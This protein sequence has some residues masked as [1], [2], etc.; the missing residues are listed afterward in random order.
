MRGEAAGTVTCI[1]DHRGAIDRASEFPGSAV[2][3][4]AFTAVSGHPDAPFVV[5]VAAVA[6]GAIEGGEPRV[7]VE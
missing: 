1:Y 3:L 5:G 7:Q 6:F 4:R 2:S